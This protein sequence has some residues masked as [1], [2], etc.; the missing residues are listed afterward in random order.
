[1]KSLNVESAA[2]MEELGRQLAVISQAGMRFYLKGSL[3]AGKTTLARGFIQGLGYE[4]KVKSP[5]YTLVESYVTKIIPVYHFD[6]YR[7]HDPM[8]LEAL[9]WRDYLDGQG[10]CLL[11]W[12]EQAAAL[13]GEPDVF[14]DIDIQGHGRKITLE[15]HSELGRCLLE[16]L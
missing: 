6:L 11:E 13:V 8:E 10:I 14:I 5:T 4:G 1:M 15:S 12:P 2:A 3:G 7:L 16:Q 9:G